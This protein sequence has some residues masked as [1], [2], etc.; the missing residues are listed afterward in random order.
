[1]PHHNRRKNMVGGFPTFGQMLVPL[2]LATAGYM[3]AKNADG[4]GG[5]EVPYLQD[6]SDEVSSL[7]SSLFGAV[8]NVTESAY[9][10]VSDVADDVTDTAESVADDVTDT[11]VRVKPSS[12]AR[13]GGKVAKYQSYN[14]LMDDFRKY[15]GQYGGNFRGVLSDLAVPA[16][17]TASAFMLNPGDEPQEPSARRVQ[18][19]GGDV[20]TAVLR[21]LNDLIVP[22]GLMSGAVLLRGKQTAVQRA[23]R[24]GQGWMTVA[25]DLSVPLGLTFAAHYMKKANDDMVGG[26]NL[27]IIGDTVLGKWMTNNNVGILTPSTLLPLGVIFLLYMAYKRYSADADVAPP[28]IS[29]LA[30]HDDIVKYNN[31]QGIQKMRK[32]T[33]YPF[34]LA[35]GPETFG[36]YVRQKVK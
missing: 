1:M 22:L 23:Q 25:M 36:E 17:L 30:D 6:I 28:H 5:F 7:A 11:R 10:E 27:P 4:S 3:L 24:G 2:G 19:V 14:E 12:S 15:G 31:A 21:T 8:E 35:M 26:A 33:Q 32:S 16:V 13:V 18:M 34:A 20:Q 29:E 9:D